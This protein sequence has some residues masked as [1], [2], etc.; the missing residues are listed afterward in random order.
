MAEY[1]AL[2]RP[3]A[4]CVVVP[5]RGKRQAAVLCG[6]APRAGYGASGGSAGGYR[7]GAKGYKM[8]DTS[9]PYNFVGAEKQFD[10]VSNHIRYLNDKMLEAYYSFVR[11]FIAIVGGSFW[12][13][14][15]PRITP[16]NAPTYA[17]LSVGLLCFIAMLA[18]IF[19]FENLRSWHNYRAQQS[20]L[21]GINPKGRARIPPPRAIRASV[22]EGCMIASIWLATLGFWYWNPFTLVFS[23]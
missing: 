19:I 2:F 16:I 23:N 13:S 10:F 6:A 12:L 11:L 4:L 22:S 18:T 3:T 7:G 8:S 14:F 15:Q 1:A 5:D 20:M 17:N 9:D 21:A